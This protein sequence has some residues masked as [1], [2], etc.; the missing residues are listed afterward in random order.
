MSHWSV[1]II[2]ISP[3]GFSTLFVDRSLTT[4][5]GTR[6]WCFLERVKT[7]IWADSVLRLTFGTFTKETTTWPVTWCTAR[8]TKGSTPRSFTRSKVKVEQWS[9]IR[10]ECSTPLSA[11]TASSSCPS[12]V[13]SFWRIWNE[14]QSWSSGNRSIHTRPRPMRL[15][16][17]LIL[18]IETPS[19]PSSPLPCAATTPGAVGKVATVPKKSKLEG[20]GSN[21]SHRMMNDATNTDTKNATVS[22]N[23]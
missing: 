23:V 21:A 8:V 14:W 1:L 18:E 20:D 3:L 17:D 5:H 19:S 16:L 10:P 2:N 15:G 6:R 22:K 11:M 12:R 13:M 7:R 9:N 4:G